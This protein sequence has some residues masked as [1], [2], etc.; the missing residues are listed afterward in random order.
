[1]KRILNNGGFP[2]HSRHSPTLPGHP[3][4]LKQILIWGGQIN[5]CGKQN[6]HRFAMGLP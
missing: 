4:C 1:M 5:G 6:G 2:I 3:D